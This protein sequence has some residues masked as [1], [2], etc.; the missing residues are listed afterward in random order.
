MHSIS[1]PFCIGDTVRLNSGGPD[2]MV[3]DFDYGTVTVAY[4][5]IHG[6]RETRFQTGCLEFIKADKS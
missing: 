5:T 4:R 3:V 2:M 6:I 1:T